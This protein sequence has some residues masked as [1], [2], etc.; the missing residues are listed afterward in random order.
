[1]LLTT[2]AFCEDETKFQ[3]Y[4]QKNEEPLLFNFNGFPYVSFYMPR[5]NPR[6]GSRYSF[7][8]AFHFFAINNDYESEYYNSL[9]HS[10]MMDNDTYTSPDE[11]KTK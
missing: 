5:Y 1:M 10:K 8:P 7:G 6:Y 11:F 2:C 9:R 3:Q 4:V